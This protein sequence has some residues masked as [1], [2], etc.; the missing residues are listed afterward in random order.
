MPWI[1]FGSKKLLILEL[2]AD[3]DLVGHLDTRKRE[4]R[5]LVL[6]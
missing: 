5:I 2:V 4:G 3:P 1:C 6:L